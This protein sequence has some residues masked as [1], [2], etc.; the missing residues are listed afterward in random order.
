MLL[1][2]QSM[3]CLVSLLVAKNVRTISFRDFNI[4]EAKKCSFLNEGLLLTASRVAHIVPP[5]S[6]DIHL[7]QGPPIYLNPNL[8][9]LQKL[10]NHPYCLRRSPLV[11]WLSYWTGLTLIRI[12]GLVFCGIRLGRYQSSNWKLLFRPS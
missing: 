4:D 2:L 9:H 6:H 8:H 7:C 1:A 5:R 12:D 3:V 11:W 10:D